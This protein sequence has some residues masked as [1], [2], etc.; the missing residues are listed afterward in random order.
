MSIY[1]FINK[2]QFSITLNHVIESI[3]MGMWIELGVFV[4]A[5]AFGIWQIQDVKKAREQTRRA[6]QNEQKKMGE[7]SPPQ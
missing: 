2:C 6:K 7:E 3:D 5:L 1:I 4:L